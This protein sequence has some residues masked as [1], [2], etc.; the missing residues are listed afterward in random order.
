MPSSLALTCRLAVLSARRLW[1]TLQ[2]KHLCYQSFLPARV[3][4][5]TVASSMLTN[6]QYTLNKVSWDS[7]AHKTSLYAD[8]WTNPC[9]QRLAGTDLCIPTHTPVLGAMVQD[10]IAAF[11]QSLQNRTAPNEDWLWSWQLKM[12]TRWRRES[13][14]IQNM[15]LLMDDRFGTLAGSQTHSPRTVKVIWVLFYY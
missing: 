3:T 2:R 1:R 6:W 13:R 14:V 10:Q 7:N 8:Q 9:G 11:K 12:L 4:G 15:E 5:L